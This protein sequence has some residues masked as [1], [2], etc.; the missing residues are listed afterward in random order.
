MWST[1]FQTATYHASYEDA[2]TDGTARTEGG[3]VR[4]NSRSR[5]IRGGCWDDPAEDCRSAFRSRDHAGFRIVYLGFRPA[6]F[7]P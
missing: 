2:P 3:E 7:L 4:L 5:V 1:Y 6:L